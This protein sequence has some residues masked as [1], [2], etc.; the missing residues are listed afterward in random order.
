MVTANWQPSSHCAFGGPYRGLAV[1]VARDIDILPLC[2]TPS[3]NTATAPCGRSPSDKIGARD[4][5][6]SSHGEELMF[7]FSWAG[8]ALVVRPSSLHLQSLPGCVVTPPYSALI[9]LMTFSLS[10]L[11]L[12]PP[13]APRSP[14]SPTTLLAEA[15]PSPHNLVLP[16]TSTPPYRPSAAGCAD[17]PRNPADHRPATSIARSPAPCLPSASVS[18]R[19]PRASGK[20]TFA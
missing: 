1:V 13:V 17:N 18:R 14:I 16:G 3:G 19:L 10:G 5:V 7:P 2:L 12:A 20:P 6:V 8:G 11:A 4:A 15:H 9:S